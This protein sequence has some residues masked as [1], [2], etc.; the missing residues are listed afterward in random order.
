[1]DFSKDP[2]ARHHHLHKP[3]GEP[4]AS[5]ERPCRPVL[6]LGPE[7]GLKQVLIHDFMYSSTSTLRKILP[8]CD[9]VLFHILNTVLSEKDLAELNT[10]FGGSVIARQ[11]DFYPP[12]AEEY[13]WTILNSLE[14][15]YSSFQAIVVYDFLFLHEPEVTELV[16]RHYEYSNTSVIIM[17]IEGT[18]DLSVIN[19][20]FHVNWTTITYTKRTIKLTNKGRKIIGANPFLG[21]SVYT[22]ALYVAG[23]HHEELFYEYLNPAD[24]DYSDSDMEDDEPPTPGSGSPVV[25]HIDD[26]GLKSVSY[27]GFVNGLDVSYGHIILRL[28]YAAHH[29]MAADVADEEEY[30]SLRIM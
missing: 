27:F 23:R 22:K 14:R 21:D 13:D 6:F 19:Q 10:V 2:P 30:S 1:M 12:G 29:N 25:T 5:C 3:S 9:S 8:C 15:Q 17:C 4:P 11:Q 18:F 26:D 7:Q 20:S 28:C 16:T 24:Y